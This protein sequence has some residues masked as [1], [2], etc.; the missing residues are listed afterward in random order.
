MENK[1]IKYFIYDD[2]NKLFLNKLFLKDDYK[3]FNFRKIFN[4]KFKRIFFLIKFLI[5]NLF[6]FKNMMILIKDGFH[7]AIV[8][9]E[10]K[11]Y[12]PK[13]VIT[14]TDNDLRFYLLKQYFDK[15]I[16]FIAI[17]NGIRSKFLDMFDNP[18]LKSQKENLTADYYLSFGNNIKNIL[19][20]YIR[21]KVISIGSFKSNF[22]I[23]KKKFSSYSQKNC[24]LYISTFRN[25]SKIEI[26]GRSLNN[27]IVYYKNLLNEEIILIKQ[28]KKYCLKYNLKLS[29]AG[30]SLSS[31]NNEI[32]FYK[33]ILS[34]CKWKFYKRE[35]IFSNYRLL[36]Q[37]EIIVTNGSTL[38]YE[39][40]G[41]NKK[42]AFFFRNFSPYKKDWLYGWP[43]QRLPKGFF[44]SNSLIENEI[45]RVLNNLRNVKNSK[46]RSILLR[47]K[48]RY[49]HF[50]IGNNK[51]KDILSGKI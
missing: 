50:Y 42:V 38:G 51:L 9:N 16:K 4:P 13:F 29:I 31:S 46:W 7:V 17:Q 43:D 15:N 23:T 36:D 3:I 40:L 39:A 19:N 45:S 34:N 20:K 32:K 10:I 48:N 24:I 44:Y 12:K 5:Q 8:F 41:R 26:L 6:S 25:R 22:V 47:E 14:T 11:N 35:D 21:T 33:N 37:F 2:C 1:N 27:Q 28:L 18:L 30:S 49:M